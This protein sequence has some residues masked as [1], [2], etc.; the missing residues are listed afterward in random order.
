M[1]SRNN[2]T[3]IWLASGIALGLGTETGASKVP[4]PLG[5]AFWWGARLP[6]N[7]SYNLRGRM[8]LWGTFKEDKGTDGVAQGRPLWGGYFKQR[9][10]WD[11]INNN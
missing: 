7:Q 10:E 3:N 4:V 8:A 11:E 6:S 9:P 1:K 2:T 5:A